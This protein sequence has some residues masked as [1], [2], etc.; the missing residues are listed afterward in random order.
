M[1]LHK[2][3]LSQKRSEYRP[4]GLKNFGECSIR[5]R[6][7]S[8][9]LGSFLLVEEK[10]IRTHL[11]GN[12]RVLYIKGK[13]LY[14]REAYCGTCHQEQGQ[15]LSASGYPPLRKVKWI[16]GNEDRLIILTLKGI[17][18]PISVLR[19]DY[20]GNVPMTPFEGLMT[21]DEVAA[22]LTYVRNSFGNRASAVL[23]EKVKT[24]RAEIKDKKGF[25]TSSELLK[26]HPF[27]D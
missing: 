26:M 27:E 9:N 22:V 10:E 13:E 16:T 12:E 24:V 7:G 5:L 18:G 4:L 15:G 20:A 14:E 17:Y 2:N 21:D 6:W 1:F 25:F 3:A 11:E 19:R 23:P 8:Q